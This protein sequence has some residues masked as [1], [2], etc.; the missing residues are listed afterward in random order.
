MLK[1]NGGL[2]RI[3]LSVAILVVF[4]LAMSGCAEKEPEEFNQVT[5]LLDWTPAPVFRLFS[6][7]KFIGKSCIYIG[8]FF[9]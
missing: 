1:L 6:P 2:F 8:D 5:V 9:D 7:Q 4:A 3:L